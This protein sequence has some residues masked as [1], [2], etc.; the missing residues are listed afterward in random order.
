MTT[1]T[2][3]T[4]CADPMFELDRLLSGVALGSQSIPE[5]DPGLDLA[6]GQQTTFR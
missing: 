4:R 2:T 1:A 6:Q 5:L 3:L